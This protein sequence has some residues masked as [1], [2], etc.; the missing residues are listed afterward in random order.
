MEEQ[1]R[2]LKAKIEK[3]KS[4]LIL[5][6]SKAGKNFLKSLE[7]EIKDKTSE[8][9]ASFRKVGHVELITLVVELEALMNLLETIN[10]AEQKVDALMEEYNELD[11]ESKQ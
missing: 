11:K 10:N 7:D 3:Q 1:L 9:I 5:K 6:E 2:D 4:Y 8:I